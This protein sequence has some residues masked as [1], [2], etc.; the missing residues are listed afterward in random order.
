L[1]G[2]R[3]REFSRA[4]LRLLISHELGTMARDNPEEK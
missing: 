1:N 2:R 4:T 3:V